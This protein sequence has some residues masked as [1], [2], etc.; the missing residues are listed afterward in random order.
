ME[1]QTLYVPPPMSVRTT[2]L[3]Y[4]KNVKHAKQ[5][6]LYAHTAFSY[7][8]LT[9]CGIFKIKSSQPPGG[10]PGGWKIEYEPKIQICKIC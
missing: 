9:I 5:Y 1:N 2:S 7:F 3:L 10:R 6:V 4:V 8:V